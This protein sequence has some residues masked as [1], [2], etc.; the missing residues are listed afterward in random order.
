MLAGI[1]ELTV[2]TRDSDMDVLRQVFV[3][4]QYDI[5]DGAHREW[6]RRRYERILSEGGTPIVI[7]AGANIGAASL[8]FSQQYP[9]ARVIA[10]EPDR[11]NV[12]ICRKNVAG[13]SN[14]EVRLDAI[15]GTSGRVAVLAVDD[16]MSWGVQT[17]RADAAVAEHGSVGVVT[18]A[19][20]MKAAGDGAELFL[21][22]VDIEGFEDDLFRHNTEWLDDVSALYIET[23]DSL[24]PGQGKS[25]PLQR[26][27]FDQGFEILLR[28]ET[29]TF[30]REEGA[31][32]QPADM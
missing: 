18:V 27:I 31:V 4:R 7:D 11:E 1:G 20:I 21:V 15:G 8:W 12:E 29:M 14:I 32:G 30:L 25:I 2:R 17:T 5:G 24:F 6:L 23:H 26:A 9:L 13:R 28:G 19:D 3:E 22:K 16:G 10:V